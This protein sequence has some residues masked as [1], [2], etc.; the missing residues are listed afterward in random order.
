[1]PI[2]LLF[3]SFL[4]LP[5]QIVTAWNHELNIPRVLLCERKLV[6]AAE[7]TWGQDSRTSSMP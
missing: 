2:F 6:L 7:V 4:F 3:S 1:M 5:F